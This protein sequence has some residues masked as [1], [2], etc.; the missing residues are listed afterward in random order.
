MAVYQ[1][2][3]TNN[4]QG[5]Q[6]RKEYSNFFFDQPFKLANYYAGYLLS[7][8]QRTIEERLQELPSMSL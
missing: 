4:S 7:E 2:A 6:R 3:K 1:F 5:F 8:T